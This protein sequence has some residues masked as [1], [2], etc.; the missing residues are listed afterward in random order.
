MSAET[1]TFLIVPDRVNIRALAEF[2]DKVLQC[3][4]YY[5]SRIAAWLRGAHSV[6]FLYWVTQVPVEYCV[7]KASL[8]T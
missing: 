1:A 5:M 6:K 2:T 3:L 4:N 7:K 8:T